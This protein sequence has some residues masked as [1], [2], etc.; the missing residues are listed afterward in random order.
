MT[1]SR[2]NPGKIADG[3]R[4]EPDEARH[5]DVVRANAPLASVQALHSA[6][7]E[8]VRPDP[9]DF[10]AERDEEAAEILNV[11]LA[12]R[13]GDHRLSPCEHGRHDD[14]LCPRHRGL[15]EEDGGGAQVLGPHRVATVRVDVGPEL[16]ERV[17]VSVQ[18]PPA[19][20]VATRRRHDRLALP[21]QQRP[22]EQDRGSDPVAELLVELVLRDGAR[23]EPDLPHAYVLYFD[24]EVGYEIEHGLHVSDRRDVRKQHRLVGE[25][26]GCHDRQGRVLVPGGTDSAVQGPAAF[27]DEG[28]RQGVGDESFRHQS[29][30]VLGQ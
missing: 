8:D 7:S 29:R 30:P 26:A 4:G 17:D 24:A 19:D 20:H 3:Y 12:R 2:S 15:V 6:N 16:R 9:A 5:F 11:R 22:R 25:Q 23:V 14:V 1:P 13:V 27:D 21:R 28:F 18:S 10:G